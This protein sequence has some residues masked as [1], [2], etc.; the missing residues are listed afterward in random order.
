MMTTT[1]ERGDLETAREEITDKLAKAHQKVR[2]L[3][4]KAALDDK[5]D[6]EL[7][8]A[9]ALVARLE[10][11]LE[12]LAD[13]MRQVERRE[14]EEEAARRLADRR[15]T[16]VKLLTRMNERLYWLG[17][18]DKAIDEARQALTKASAT[19]SLLQVHA[20]GLEG[21][22]AL[23]LAKCCAIAE[24]DVTKHA[25][26][27]LGK[28]GAYSGDVGQNFEAAVRI[29]AKHYP[30]VLNDDVDEEAALAAMRT[31]Y[32]EKFAAEDGES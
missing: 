19:S 28:V 18:M 23:F 17:K 9:N 14:S 29:L 11:K 5:F 12:G 2:D 22:Q 3:R 6:D 20:N 15:V 10:Q 26:N 21:D 25:R 30:E 31:V 24:T 1:L 16:A 8:E 4:T 7:T 27:D 13:G 32:P